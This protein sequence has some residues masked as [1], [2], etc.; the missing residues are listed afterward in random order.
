MAFLADRAVRALGRAGAPVDKATLV[1]AREL[2]ESA[3]K[4]ERLVAKQEYPVTAVRNFSDLSWTSSVLGSMIAAKS[5]K[6][7]EGTRAHLES[8]SEA[9]RCLIEEQ[10]VS[11]AARTRSRLFFKLLRDVVL[12]TSAA[13]SDV[14]EVDI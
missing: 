5:I 8:L 13:P 2:I 7:S 6:E 14:V 9:L 12:T 4:G 3:L 11:D 1:E 10:P